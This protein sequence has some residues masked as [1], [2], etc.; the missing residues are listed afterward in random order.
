MELLL[1]KKTAEN[2]ETQTKI[3]LLDFDGRVNEIARI[4]YTYNNIPVGAVMPCG[5]GDEHDTV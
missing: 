4:N 3:K 1:I 2:G 5:A